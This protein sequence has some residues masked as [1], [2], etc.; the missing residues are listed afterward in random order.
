METNSFTFQV[1]Y[2]NIESNI[3]IHGVLSDPLTPMCLR[4]WC[5]LSKLLYN[6]VAEVFSNLLNADKR[7]KE[8]K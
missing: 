7:V 2:A 5:Q 3:E 4:Q 8:Y 6:I 1:A